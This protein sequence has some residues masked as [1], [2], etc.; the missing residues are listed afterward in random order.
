MKKV[1]LGTTALVAAG[2]TA[3]A[4][5]AAPALK[6]DVNGYY[7]GVIASVDSDVASVDDVQIKHEGEIS[8]NG[9]ATLDNG[10]TAGV[11]INLEATNDVSGG[12][13]LGAATGGVAPNPFPNVGN[14]DGFA[15]IDEAYA[16]LEGSF[17]RVQIGSEASAPFLMHQ[18]APYFVGSHGVDSPNFSYQTLA[19]SGVNAQGGSARTSTYLTLSGDNNKVTYF[20]PSFSGIQLGISYTPDN[21]CNIDTG[22]QA[23]GVSNNFLNTGDCL[24]GSVPAA[25]NLED[26]IEIG[27]TYTGTI[28]NVGVNASI[29]YATADVEIPVGSGASFNDPEA[30]SFGLQL[31]SGA[32]TLGG[33]YYMS[34]N[35]GTTTATGAADREEKA[36]SVALQYVT[37]PWTVGAGYFSSENELSATSEDELKV[38][39]VGGTYSLAEGVDVFAVVE[40]YESDNNTVAGDV[41]TTAVGLGIDL[42]F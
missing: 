21:N 24:A 14:V 12:G 29:G 13:A 32:F 16:Y 8:I 40:N 39:E 2:L 17:G 6:V 22:G 15:G 18:T 11:V 31:N 5:N 3:G 36:W 4:A 42:A 38:I 34:E 26:V 37:G 41:E 23:G 28:N 20:T 19:L 9:S 33:G 30:W 1:L 27:G 10:M 35:L 25:V 7:T